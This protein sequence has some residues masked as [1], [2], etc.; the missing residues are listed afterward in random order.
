VGVGAGLLAGASWPIH[1]ALRHGSA[2]AREHFG[3]TVFW[4]FFGTVPLPRESPSCFRLLWTQYQPLTVL[5]AV[6]LGLLLWARRRTRGDA[7]H[8]LVAWVVVPLVAVSLSRWRD[9]RYLYPVLPALGL[10]S[11]H[12]LVKVARP[13]ANAVTV[14]IAPALLVASGVVYWVS[15][16]TISTPPNAQYKAF[17]PRARAEIPSGALVPFVGGRDG[18]QWEVENI[19]MWYWD[20]RPEPPCPPAA[21]VERARSRGHNALL[22]QRDRLGGL[23]SLGVAYEVPFEARFCLVRLTAPGSP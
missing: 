17:A 13:L 2:F 18:D 14:W 11:G 7:S 12:A 22:V 4:R 10:L 3:A 20:I 19:G 16:G 23:D 6:G 9:P 5:A 15:P 8:L 1:E 21:A